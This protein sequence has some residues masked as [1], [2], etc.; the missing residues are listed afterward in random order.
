MLTLRQSLTDML[1]RIDLFWQKIIEPSAA[2]QNPEQR[3]QVRLL[4]QLLIP[5]FAL[6]ILMSSWS[7]TPEL[8]FVYIVLSVVV[9]GGIYWANRRGHYLVAALLLTAL[10]AVSG[11]VNFV[12]R[13]ID[14]APTPEI[15]LTRVVLAIIVAYLILPLGWLLALAAVSLLSLLVVMLLAPASYPF[16]PV[17]FYFTAITATLMTIAG[18]ARRRQ[19]QQIAQQARQLAESEARFRNL[20]EASFEAIIVLKEGVILDTNAGIETLLGYQ[21]AEVVGRPLLDLVEPTYHRR[22]LTSYE[23]NDGVPFEALLHHQNGQALHVELRGKAQVYKGEM[24]RVI[25]IRDITELKNQEAL[26][27]E[28]EKVHALQKFIGNLSHDLRTPLT[29]INT[30]IY[31]I[32]RLAQD[33]D[34]QQHQ[35]AVLREQAVHM[36]RLL[37]DLISMSRLDKAD[38][39][40]FRF[41][42]QDVN[43]LVRLAV[44]EQ[45]K[46]AQR[47]HQTLSAQPTEV[48]P[49]VL[50]DADQ[51]MLALKHLILN[52]LTYTGEGGAVVVETGCDDR[53]VIV[54]V[55]DNGVGIDPEDMPHIFEYFYRADPARGEEGGTGVGL[56]IVRKIIEAHGGRVTVE[57][58]P[59][60]GSMFT[61][62]LPIPPR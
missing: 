31:L 22:I 41:S 44:T 34:R 16:L 42:F 27:I 55:R 59:G 36:Q 1:H 7:G 52:G 24:V 56:T 11:F 28:R 50:I 2:I 57:S 25:A 58:Q 46:L 15:G 20:L 12:L 32:N 29:I 13:N 30:S 48:L 10:V 49:E 23:T 53:D 35:I 54:I 18:L 60:Q 62:A 37:E 39:R 14:H 26:T 6:L 43:D 17:T 3:Q 51:F 40:D 19:M 4:N 47:K 61:I 9:I 33:P 8:F 45:Q 38:T 21:P 5:I